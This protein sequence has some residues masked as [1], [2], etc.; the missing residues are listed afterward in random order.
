[1]VKVE[2]ECKEGEIALMVSGKNGS[3]FLSPVRGAV[4][5]AIR[6]TD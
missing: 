2:I 1:M 5:E 3:A 6:D 4:S